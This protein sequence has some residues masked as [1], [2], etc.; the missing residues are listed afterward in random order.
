MKSLCARSMQHNLVPFTF[1]VRSVQYDGILAG[2]NMP[3]AIMFRSNLLHDIWRC[4]RINNV[5]KHIIRY[6]A[7][8]GHDTVSREVKN[9]FAKYLTIDAGANLYRPKTLHKFAL[10]IVLIK[11]WHDNLSVFNNTVFVIPNV[12]LSNTE[13]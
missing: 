3:I 5:T 2:M 7:Y 13:T 9:D 1:V 6:R 11:K 4:V 12:I 8:P 10:L